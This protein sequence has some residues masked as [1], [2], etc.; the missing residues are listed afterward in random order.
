MQ[1][2]QKGVRCHTGGVAPDDVQSAG[3]L[4]KPTKPF[5]GPYCNWSSPKL[6]ISSA[7]LRQMAGKRALPWSCPGIGKAGPMSSPFLLKEMVLESQSREQPMTSFC[8][9]GAPYVSNCLLVD[10]LPAVKQS[11]PYITLRMSHLFYM[12]FIA[13]TK[14]TALAPFFPFC[15]A[16]QTALAH[17]A[18]RMLTLPAANTSLQNKRTVSDDEHSPI[19]C[20]VGQPSLTS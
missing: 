10:F 7:F 2:S 18:S 15:T 16:S 13:C 4:A 19:L 6:T 3:A 5:G 12:K 9:Y 8:P 11:S 1:T 17:S 20:I 14:Q